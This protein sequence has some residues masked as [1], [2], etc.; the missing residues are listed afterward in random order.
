M[1]HG[2]SRM[3]ETTDLYWSVVVVHK[4]INV[5]I[6]LANIHFASYMDTLNVIHVIHVMVL[7]QT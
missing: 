1:Q 2:K 4:S 6:I 3:L 5:S 7:R